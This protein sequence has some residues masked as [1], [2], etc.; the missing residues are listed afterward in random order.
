MYIIQGLDSL[1]YWTILAHSEVKVVAVFIL[2]IEL[3][4]DR[5]LGLKLKF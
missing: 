4:L 1:N 5:K 3:Y 2:Y